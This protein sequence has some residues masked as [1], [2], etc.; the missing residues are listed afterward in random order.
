MQ[1][2]ITEFSHNESLK[3]YKKHTVAEANICWTLLICQ[4]IMGS[5]GQHLQPAVYGGVLLS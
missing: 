2:D 3:S 1:E 4:H 5:N